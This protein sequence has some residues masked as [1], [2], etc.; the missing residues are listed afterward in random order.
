MG[1]NELEAF[2]PKIL[3]NNYHFLLKKVR[4]LIGTKYSD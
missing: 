2:I 3:L 4:F 1:R